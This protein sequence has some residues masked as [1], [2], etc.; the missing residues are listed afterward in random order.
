M[1]HFPDATRPFID[2]S[3]GINPDA[4]PLRMPPP[5]SLTRLPEEEDDHALREA[6]AIAYG[7]AAPD[8]IATGPGSQS[9]I[10]L[11]PRLV[12]APRA[13]LWEPTYSGH[14]T[15][16]QQAG[17][18]LQHV[19][20]LASFMR[21][22]ARESTACILCNPNNPDGRIL[23]A[24]QLREL[25]DLCASHGNHLVVDEAFADFDA[26]SLIPVL[27]H[28][29]LIILRS[30]GKTW[31][32]PGVR[33]GFLLASPETAEQARNLVGAWPVST[34]AL[35]VGGQALRDRE[36][37]DRARLTASQAKNRLVGLLDRTGL[38]SEGQASLFT[39]VRTDRATDLWTHLC[40][41]GIITRLFSTE[42][43]SLR[44]GLPGAE[45]AWQRLEA[46]LAEWRQQAPLSPGAHTDD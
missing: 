9:L 43:D 21:E 11:L 5:G 24:T 19:S 32:L 6:A 30:F 4:Y 31:G 15:S 45:E 39:L 44:L 29:G 16:W 35:A 13:C 1:R 12:P 7:A 28:P 23:P 10:S 26:E 25:A 34:L 18:T 3:T 33:L 20:D 46:V 36:W 17:A 42:S 2:L 40:R 41:H 14:A 8:M 38:R 27:P 37:L 22:A